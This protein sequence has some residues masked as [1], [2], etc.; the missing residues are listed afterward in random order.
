MTVPQRVFLPVTY[1][2]HKR[3]H[4]AF[5]LLPALDSAAQADTKSKASDAFHAWIVLAI[6]GRAM[7]GPPPPKGY[8]DRRTRENTCFLSIQAISNQCKRSPATVRRALD[9]LLD[10]GFITK[11]WV[12]PEQRNIG[13][14]LEIKHAN[15]RYHL[16]EELWNPT[17]LPDEDPEVADGDED[18]NEEGMEDRIE[19]SEAAVDIFYRVKESPHC[20]DDL[21][22]VFEDV[23]RC[24]EFCAAVDGMKARKFSYTEIEEVLLFALQNSKYQRLLVQS[25]S[26]TTQIGKHFPSWLEA[27]NKEQR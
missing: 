27:M 19:V 10:W 20:G 24:D 3:L 12:C 7:A 6:L 23:N 11:S 2:N 26:F 17:I 14:H 21:Q 8:K 16:V 15:C 22:R 18:G 1:C 25:R 4:Q 13:S 5:D 9:H